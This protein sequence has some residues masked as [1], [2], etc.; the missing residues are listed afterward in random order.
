MIRPPRRSVTR[1]FIPLIDV[2]ILMFGIFL[3]MPL[4]EE[5]AAGAGG[6]SRLTAGEA[7]QLRQDRDRLQQRIA[8]LERTKESDPALRR[9][10]AADRR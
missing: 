9:R 2:L 1:F 4:V 8:E 3:L 5:G 10:I 6:E 7:E